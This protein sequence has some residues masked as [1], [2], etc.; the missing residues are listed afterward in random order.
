MKIKLLIILSAIA[1]MS[2][3]CTQ[4]SQSRQNSVNEVNGAIATQPSQ[5]PLTVINEGTTATYGSEPAPDPL[6]E[7]AKSDTKEN[8]KVQ[9]ICNQSFNK[10]TGERLPTTFAWTEKGKIAIVRWKTEEFASY[11][12]QRRCDEVSPRFQE[13]YDNGTLKMITNGRMNGQPVICTATAYRGECQT[14]LMTLRSTD[15]SLRVLNSFNDVLS[16]R[17]TGPILHNSGSPQVYYQVDIETFL[18]T[19]PVEE[20]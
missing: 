20:Q 14:L 2:F 8:Q 3:G 5:Q 19:A 17:S 9:F 4:N 7:P 18:R 11:S 15:D 10:G 16:G 12:P 13:A 1:V 6:P